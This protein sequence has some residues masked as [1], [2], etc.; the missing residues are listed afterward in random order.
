[1]ATGGD[2]KFELRHVA[3]GVV[4]RFEQDDGDGTGV[5]EV[6]YQEPDG[7]EVEAFAEFLWLVAENYGPST[8]RY[9]A[10]RIRI[11]VEPGD[12]YEGAPPATVKPRPK[13]RS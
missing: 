5:E 12:K 4:L 11:S 10:K 1:M 3:N 7:G 8:S 6:V 9:S 2:M 13:Q